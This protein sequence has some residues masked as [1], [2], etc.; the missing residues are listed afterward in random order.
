MATSSSSGGG[1]GLPAGTRIGKYEVREK[2]GAGG[3][4]VVYKCYDE[5]LDRYVAAK[6]ISAHLA[7]DGRFLR[8]FRREAKILARLGGE[9]PGIVTIHELIEDERGLFIIMEFVEGATLESI[10]ASGQAPVAPRTAVQLL[11]R[12]AA[13]MNAVHAAGIIHRDLKPSNVIVA[14]GLRPTITDFGVAASISGQTSMILGTTKYMAPEL[15]GGGSVDGRTDMYSLGFIIYELLL[16]REK[17]EEIFADIVRDPRIATVRWMKWHGNQAVQ[18]PALSQVNPAIPTAL[19]ALVARMIAKDPDDRYENMESLGLAIRTELA[20]V[21]LA[22]EARVAEPGAA[23]AL[24][25]EPQD[26]ELAPLEP[27]FDEEELEKTPTAP[28]PK[29]T[30]SKRTK[31]ILLGAIAL[32]TVAFIVGLAIRSHLRAQRASQSAQGVYAAAI[33]AYEAR[34]YE[35]ALEK[36]KEVRRRFGDTREAAKASVLGPMSR[37]YLAI[38]GEEWE[39]AARAEDEAQDGVE[40]VQRAYTDQEMVAWTRQW[41]QKVKDLT[42]YRINHRDHRETFRRAKQYAAQGRYD[43]AIRE[44]GTS[45]ASLTE[46]QEKEVEDFLTEMRRK[47]VTAKYEGLRADADE[48]IK[49]G[50]ESRALSLLEAMRAL[51]DGEAARVALSPQQR[52][53]WRQEIRSRRAG[54]SQAAKVRRVQK[55]IEQARRDKD[56]QAELDA[57]GQLYELKPD[58]RTADRILELRLEILYEQGVSYRQAGEI[59]KATDAFVQCLRLKEDYEPAQ[60][61]L[62]ELNR[63][64]GL[65][66]LLEQA[67]RALDEQRWATA[68]ELYRQAY[69]QQADA[70]VARKIKVCQ[71]RMLLAEAQK[72]AGQGDYEQAKRK[73]AEAGLKDPSLM[74]TEVTPAIEAIERIQDRQALIGE[75]KALLAKKKG[76]KARQKFEYAKNLSETKDEED[77]ADKLIIQ[78]DYGKFIDLGKKA[79]ASGDWIRAKAWFEA[80]RGKM[81]TKEAAELLAEAEAKIWEE[82]NK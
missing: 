6:Q 51:A 7:E 23:V 72:L 60:R 10:L 20:G 29:S 55:T 82:E 22:D 37:A 52:E 26:D 42:I 38:Q 34:D 68:L 77:E 79:M 64:A 41:D 24:P 46:E 14:E 53:T 47:S 25:E 73:Y 74:D 76:A 5:L 54:I 48:A 28:L 21:P 65:R 78:A 43:D 75:G 13:A 50:D 27:I 32:T 45:R 1:V 49:R 40:N 35:T 39:E 71:A 15:F 2:I 12:L 58:Q 56:K 18:A 3:Q 61:E 33:Q 70:Q 36:F 57:L 67:D 16:G 59:R 63:E 80:A 44:M 81:A 9:Q 19:S 31:L 66:A 69:E 11:W 30:L 62:E 17:F 4:S 8:H